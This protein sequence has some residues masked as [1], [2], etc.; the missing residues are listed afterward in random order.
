MISNVDMETVNV[1][2]LDDLT[3]GR[4]VRLARIAKG[5]RQLDVASITGLNPGDVCNV[6]LD[7]PVHRWKLKRILDTLALGRRP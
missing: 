6:E 7:R 1:I 2:V 3:L 4:R 5:L